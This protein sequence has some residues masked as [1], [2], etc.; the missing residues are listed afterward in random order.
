MGIGI[1]VS[2]IAFNIKRPLTYRH[3][4]ET[5]C[6][7]LIFDYVIFELKPLCEK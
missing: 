2:I 6:F 3:Q 1:Q 7:F 5:E 4:K